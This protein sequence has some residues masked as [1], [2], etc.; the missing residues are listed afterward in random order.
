MNRTLTNLSICMAALAA[1]ACGDTITQ[2]VNLA[3]TQNPFT[4]NIAVQGFDAS[5][6]TLNSVNVLLSSTVNA[7]FRITN[8]G[9][10]TEIATGASASIPV[11]LTGPDGLSILTTATSAS[12]FSLSADP[13]PPSYFVA[14]P[15]ATATASVDVTTNLGS[16]TGAALTIPFTV[17]AMN[18]SYSGTG[19]ADLNYG[20]QAFSSESITVTYTYTALDNSINSIPEPGVMLTA[21][22]GLMGVAFALKFLKKKS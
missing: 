19:G 4:T 16:Y 17:S 14:G 20:G 1:S 3:S 8:F 5:L 9:S 6:G 12:N 22:T 21:G 7:T 10:A 13:F 2:V 18:G 11:G 15:A